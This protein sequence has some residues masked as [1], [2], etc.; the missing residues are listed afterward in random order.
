MFGLDFSPVARCIDSEV[1]T[2][3]VAAIVM[4]QYQLSIGCMLGLFCI[5]CI[6]QNSNTMQYYE[7]CKYVLL[8]VHFC[9]ILRS[10]Y[11]RSWFDLVLFAYYLVTD[12][13]A[14]QNAARKKFFRR[15]AFGILVLFILY[16]CLPSF[17][18]APQSNDLANPKWFGAI[19]RLNYIKDDC[20]NKGYCRMITS[21]DYTTNV[22]AG[23]V[24]KLF[25]SFKDGFPVGPLSF[26]VGLQVH[27]STIRA[28]ELDNVS[29]SS[30]FN[31]D[32]ALNLSFAVTYTEVVED[33]LTLARVVYKSN[34]V[35]F[36]EVNCK[37]PNIDNIDAEATI[38]CNFRDTEYT[39]VSA[40]EYMFG[41]LAVGTLSSL[42]MTNLRLM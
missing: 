5:Y 41:M 26:P 37:L 19:A 28:N 8:H 12:Y 23:H 33:T 2:F 27:Q 4:S 13:S 40:F 22:T 30:L 9:L 7:T 21:Y 32:S 1:I 15:C 6:M 11:T 39:I 34:F 29:L 25:D 17:S 16:C 18:P 38:E 14:L 31:W 20:E 3:F 42:V 36:K 10:L 35:S 24:L